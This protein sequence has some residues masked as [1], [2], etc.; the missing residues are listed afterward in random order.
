MRCFPLGCVVRIGSHEAAQARDVF[1]AE[2][3]SDTTT[4]LIV[5]PV[6]EVMNAFNAPSIFPLFRLAPMLRTLDNASV[7]QYSGTIQYVLRLIAME[8][9]HKSSTSSC[10]LALEQQGVNWLFSAFSLAFR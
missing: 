4:I 10:D 8:I 6:D 1:Q 2:A 7:D 5:V 9:H 3:G